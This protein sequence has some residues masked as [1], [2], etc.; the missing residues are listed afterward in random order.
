MCTPKHLIQ[1]LEEYI[2]QKK[3]KLEKLGKCFTPIYDEKGKPIYLIFS[4][5][6]GYPNHPDRMGIQWRDIVAKYKLSKITF[7][8]LRHTYASFALIN[9]VNIKVIQEQLGHANIQETLNTYS[10]IS[11][12]LK[13]QSVNI[14]DSFQ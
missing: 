9:G 11:A 1:E 6:N 13:S 10:H 4:K 7:H 8:G 5:D 3:K 14:F 2:N 12:D